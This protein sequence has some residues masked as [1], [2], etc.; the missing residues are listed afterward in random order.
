MNDGRRFNE[1]EIREVFERAAT[2]Q[3]RAARR[4]ADDGLTV[5]EMQEVAASA[6]IAPEFVTAAARSVALGEPENGRETFGPIPTG[7]YRTEH[8]PGPPTDALWEHLVAD[9][10][11]TFAARGKV[12]TV[13]QFREW[14]NGNLRAVLEPSGDGSRLRFRTRR[15]GIPASLAT[16]A[17]L[18]GALLVAVAGASSPS[19]FLALLLLIVGGGGAAV[20]VWARQRTWAETREHQMQAVAERAAATAALSA[21]ATLPD[22]EARPALDPGS[23]LGQALDALPDA[24]DAPERSFSRR[25]TKG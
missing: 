21:P 4:S 22:A 16:F 14:R 5:E 2:E 24:P 9:L 25:R 23:G 11:H 19:A 7:V 1:R 10:R 18:A 13:G 20:S 12:E 3:E 17:V 15:D 6:G 8:L